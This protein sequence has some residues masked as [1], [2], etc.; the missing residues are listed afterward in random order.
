MIQN[1]KDNLKHKIFAALCKPGMQKGVDRAQDGR[2]H[3]ALASEQ[4]SIESGAEFGSKKLR[5]FSPD[6]FAFSMKEEAEIVT[7]AELV[8]A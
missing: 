7:K 6:S 8:A 3:C 2:Q 4:N 5:K 1:K